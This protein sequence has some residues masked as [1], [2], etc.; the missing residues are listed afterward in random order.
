VKK[1]PQKVAQNFD[2]LRAVDLARIYS[3]SESA[4]SHWVSRDACPRRAD[5]A[6]DLGEVIRWREARLQ[7]AADELALNGAGSQSLERW[8]SARATQEELKL[9]AIEGTLLDAGEVERGRIQ[10]ILVIRRARL[11]RRLTRGS[12]R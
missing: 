10:R 1:K 3:V 11:R 7:R 8:R 6:Y 5:G 2:Q 9:K 12:K 4:I